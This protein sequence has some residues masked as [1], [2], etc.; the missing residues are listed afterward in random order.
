MSKGDDSSRTSRKYRSDVRWLIKVKISTKNRTCFMQF[1]YILLQI[2][3]DDEIKVSLGLPRVSGS[4]LHFPT[5]VATAQPIRAETRAEP[6]ICRQALPLCSRVL[7]VGQ[8]IKATSGRLKRRERRRT[9][10]GHRSGS[11]NIIY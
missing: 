2:R 10:R 8:T 5:A 11:V 3:T 4:A 1:S 6:R 7:E 9:L